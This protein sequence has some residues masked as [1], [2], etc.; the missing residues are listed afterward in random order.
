MVLGVTRFARPFLRSVKDAAD[1]NDL[2]PDAVDD[3]VRKRY[4]YEFAGICR[5]PSASAVG[6]L[7]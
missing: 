4:Q 6:K 2:F 1:L 5:L 3:H 7:P